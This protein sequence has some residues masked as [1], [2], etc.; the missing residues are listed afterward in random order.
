MSEINSLN[1]TVAWIVFCSSCWLE[2]W[3]LG[4]GSAPCPLFTVQLYPVPSPALGLTESLTHHCSPQVWSLEPP[5]PPHLG[6]LSTFPLTWDA[7]LQA[8]LLYFSTLASCLC[9]GS[10]RT[11]TF[12]SVLESWQGPSRSSW[13]LGHSCIG[14]AS[15][16]EG[17]NQP[18]AVLAGKSR[19]APSPASLGWNLG[20]HSISVLHVSAGPG[21]SWCMQG[22]V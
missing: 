6:S 18:H 12:S 13:E 17:W 19:E 16:K 10:G 14:S 15:P 21:E 5:A 1:Q 4:L 8:N 2:P 3:L 11:D 9:P 20:F 7:E 22:R